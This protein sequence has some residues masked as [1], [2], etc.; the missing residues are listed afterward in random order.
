MYRDKIESLGVDHNPIVFIV[1][2][3]QAHTANLG[4]LTLSL[5]GSNF[6]PKNLLI[7]G[8]LKSDHFFNP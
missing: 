6:Y 4:R 3:I 2:F 8:A 1:N 7:A 5:I